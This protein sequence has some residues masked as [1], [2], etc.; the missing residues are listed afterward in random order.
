MR[1]GPKPRPL[2]GGASGVSLPAAGGSVKPSLG[3]LPPPWGL[4]VSSG[5]PSYLCVLQ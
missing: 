5:T 4:C 3:F 1:D 2:L